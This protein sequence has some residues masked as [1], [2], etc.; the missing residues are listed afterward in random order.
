MSSQKNNR[1]KHFDP[2]SREW[3]SGQLV[4]KVWLAGIGR[5]IQCPYCQAYTK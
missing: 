4:E 1:G 2:S 3:V 5:D